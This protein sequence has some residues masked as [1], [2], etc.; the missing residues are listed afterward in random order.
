MGASPNGEAF[1]DTAGDFDVSGDY[2]EVVVQGSYT[3]ASTDHGHRERSC[4]S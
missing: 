3:S 1:F 4:L 2:C